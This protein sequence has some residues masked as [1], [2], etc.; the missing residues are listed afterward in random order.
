MTPWTTFGDLLIKFTDLI[1]KG[2][3]SLLKQ[4]RDKRD[5]VANYFETIASTLLEAASE[6]EKKERPWRA[7]IEVS[8]TLENFRDIVKDIVGNEKNVEM[9]YHQLTDICLADFQLLNPESINAEE[10]N[11]VR[12]ISRDLSIVYTSLYDNNNPINQLSKDDLNLIIRNEVDKI[13][14]VAGLFKG[15]AIELKAT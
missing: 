3:D 10:R 14:K 1:F 6:F 5:R 4:K 13:R 7:Y 2:K 15:A 8:Y 9:L 12:S 11:A